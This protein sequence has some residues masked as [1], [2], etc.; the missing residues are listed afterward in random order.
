MTHWDERYSYIA[1]R[2]CGCICWAIHDD[3][4]DK[5][6]TAREIAKVVRRGLAVER[7]QSSLISVA[8]WECDLCAP[9]Q[10]KLL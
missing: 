5:D 6:Y 1:R 10:G 7:I 4:A 3:P 2:P 9:K 8:M